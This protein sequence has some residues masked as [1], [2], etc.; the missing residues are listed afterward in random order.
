MKNDIKNDLLRKIK[1]FSSLSEEELDE[2]TRNM[3][4][5]R[6][7]KNQ[8]VLYEEDTNEYMY[9]ILQGGVKVIQTT[10]DG[11]EVI[12]AIHQAGDFFGELSLIDNKTSP[13]LVQATEDST[14]A[15][16][17]R[18]DFMS[19]IYTQD[20]V[21]DI[22]LQIMCARLRESWD[23]IQILSFN[24]ASQRIKMMFLHLTAE[25]GRKTAEGVLLDIKLTHQAIAN[26]VGISRETAT[27]IIYKW[28]EDREIRVLKNK[29]ILL[30]HAFLEHI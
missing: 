13:A 18:K 14:I 8:P 28:H 19:L 9:M 21:L 2:I 5:K 26:M 10:Q 1:L 7:R 23:K 24:N 6:Y 11:K 20:K 15:L 17:S 30:T 3:K 27:R 25:Y 22:L 16:V 12:L 4:I 29:A